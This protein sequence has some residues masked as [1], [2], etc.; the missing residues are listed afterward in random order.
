ME[1]QIF[2]YFTNILKDRIKRIIESYEFPQKDNA[3][4]ELIAAHLFQLTQ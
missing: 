3:L 2:L 1:N 4:L